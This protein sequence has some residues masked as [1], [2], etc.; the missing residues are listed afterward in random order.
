MMRQDVFIDRG[1]TT[2]AR[3]RV[4]RDS[5]ATRASKQL[6]LA[7]DA[8]AGAPE[9]S[10]AS[11]L[12]DSVLVGL[13]Q[14]AN[15]ISASRLWVAG[16]WLSRHQRVA[17]A[18]RIRDAAIRLAG[19]ASPM[20]RSLEARVRLAQGD[21]SAAIEMLS[22]N[23]PSARKSALSWRPNESLV[24]DRML[25]A[26]LYMARGQPWEAIEWASVVDAPAV[27]ADLV[28]LPASLRIRAAAAD[29]AGDQQLSREMRR[30]LAALSRGN[31]IIQH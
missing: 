13:A 4:E 19:P 11:S 7:L 17:D 18:A 29:A 22:R 28:F 30:R 23:A 9:D 5:S 15:E 10:V 26:E 16:A 2:E 14:G 20:A 1:D 8:I 27:L 24:A 12:A 31:E 3:L 25:L 21:T 6:L